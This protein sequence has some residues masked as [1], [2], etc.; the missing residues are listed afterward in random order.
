MN[1]PK[2]E[3]TIFVEALA[4]Q[5]EQRSTYLNHATH[6]NAELRRR[7]ESLL[8]SYGAGDFMEQAAAPELR[9]TR[10]GRGGRCAGTVQR[11]RHH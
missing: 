10:I 1:T 11:Q 9:P 8:V 6:G 7:I 5:G 3:E 4:L 2:G